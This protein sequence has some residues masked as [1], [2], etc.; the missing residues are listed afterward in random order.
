MEWGRYLGQEAI[1][2]GVDVQ[3]SS[4]GGLLLTLC[5]LAKIGGST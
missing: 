3:V 2:Q 4:G 1:E 5:F